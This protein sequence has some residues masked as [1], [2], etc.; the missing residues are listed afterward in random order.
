MKNKLIKLFLPIIVAGTVLVPT[1]SVYAG[2]IITNEPPQLITE[3]ASKAVSNNDT[4]NSGIATNNDLPNTD[5]NDV[6]ASGEGLEKAERYVS[7]KMLD[8]VFF[9]QAIIKPF[10]YITFII[11]SITMILGIL[12]GSKSK[13]KGL[14]GMAFSVLVYIVVAQSPQIIDFLS[15]WMMHP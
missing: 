5:S 8:V 4:L 11:S 15:L 13:F 14:L 10:I 3:G 7:N 6:V 12:G 1:A 9:L 2:N